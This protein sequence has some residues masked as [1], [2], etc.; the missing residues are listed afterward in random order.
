MTQSKQANEGRTRTNGGV[1]VLVSSRELHLDRAAPEPRDAHFEPKEQQ[2]AL[3]WLLV[4]PVVIVVF[5]VRMQRDDWNCYRTLDA[6]LVRVS[7][8]SAVRVVD[9]VVQRL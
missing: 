5:V 9:A 2:Q 4:A 8:R 1:Y 7:F 6:F 3:S